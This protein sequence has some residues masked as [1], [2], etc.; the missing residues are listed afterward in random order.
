MFVN[1]DT[2]FAALAEVARPYMQDSIS[3]S[4]KTQEVVL[5]EGPRIRPFLY[6][7]A[8]FSPVPCCPER[9]CSPRPPR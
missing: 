6:A 1:L 8:R 2:T 9:S 4:V 5:R 3:E 7:S